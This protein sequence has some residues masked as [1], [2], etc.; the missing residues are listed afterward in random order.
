MSSSMTFHEARRSTRVALQLVIAIKGEAATRMCEGETI[1]INLYRALIS[2]ETIERWDENL[3]SCLLDGQT[4]RLS[5]GI[6]RSCESSAVRNR[7]G[8][9]AKY[10]GRA[11]AADDWQDKSLQQH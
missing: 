2:A 4:G 8:R 1:V 11:S 10:L 7:I 9:A 5:C 6:H 3:D